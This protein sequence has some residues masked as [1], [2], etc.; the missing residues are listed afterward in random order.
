MITDLALDPPEGLTYEESALWKYQ[1]YLED[2][3]ACIASV[4]DNVGRLIDLLI[5]WDWFDDTLR[6]YASDQGFFLGDH[7]WYDKR[8]IHEESIRMPMLISYPA[9][10]PAG[11][12]SERMITSVGLART[13]LEAAD[14]A[15][16]P[17][18]QGESLFADLRDELEPPQDQAMYYRYWEYDDGI[19]HSLA[20]CGIRSRPPGVG[21]RSTE[22]RGSEI[23]GASSGRRGCAQRFR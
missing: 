21:H 5:A 11:R 16:D 2:Y 7:G 20:H 9:A 23:D 18:M 1:R 10:P 14:V 22:Q 13:H 15:P 4:D 17:G 6:T 3:L 12:R 19:H 8:F